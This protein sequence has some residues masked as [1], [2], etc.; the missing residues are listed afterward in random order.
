VLKHLRIFRGQLQDDFTDLPGSLAVNMITT[1]GVESL[2]GSHLV[3]EASV[4]RQHNKPGSDSARSGS[5]GDTAVSSTPSYV[6]IGQD[7]FCLQEYYNT[8]I[9][10]GGQDTSSKA[11]EP[12]KT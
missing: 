6:N 1:C 2:N 11:T 10:D 8:V 12:D 3:F 7:S 9:T 4:W 5:G